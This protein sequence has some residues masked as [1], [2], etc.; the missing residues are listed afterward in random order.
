MTYEPRQKL[1]VQNCFRSACG[2]QHTKMNASI[3]G[4]TTFLSGGQPNEP[5]KIRAQLRRWGFR[6]MEALGELSL[7]ALSFGWNWMLLFMPDQHRWDTQ[8]FRSLLL[9]VLPIRSGA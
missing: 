3:L 6:F 4:T 9:S 2:P 7:V 1:Q 8:T 5:G